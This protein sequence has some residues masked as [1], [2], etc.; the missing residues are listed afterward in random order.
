MW[1]TDQAVWCTDQAVCCTDQAVCCTDQTVCC[2]DQAVCCT[3]QAVCCTIVVSNSGKD[4]CFLCPPKRPDCIWGPHSLL[5]SMYW[6]SSAGIK[7]PGRE[8]NNSPIPSA[9]VKI[10]SVK[11]PLVLRFQLYEQQ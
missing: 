5:V 9:E 3:D 2:T 7:R 8:P 6:S 4:E 11:V 10:L 1:C